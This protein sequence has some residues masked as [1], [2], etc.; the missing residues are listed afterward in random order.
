MQLSN[1]HSEVFRLY[2]KDQKHVL[3][4]VR[5]LDDVSG[6]T[7]DIA[8]P[9][10]KVLGCFREGSQYDL[11]S[12]WDALPQSGV[13][14]LSTLFPDM[15]CEERICGKDCASCRPPEPKGGAC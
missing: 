7:Y 6:K 1:D 13:Q 9:D 2:D 4:I 14:K 5:C 8:T 12:L 11:P 15:R 10:G 3:S